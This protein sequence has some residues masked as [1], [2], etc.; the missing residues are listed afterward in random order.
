MSSASGFYPLI[1]KA[2]SS[3]RYY[4]TSSKERSPSKSLSASKKAFEYQES[5]LLRHYSSSY[6]DASAAS[7]ERTIM[8]LNSSSA[9]L[10]S[11]YKSTWLN[12]YC[13]SSLSYS[14][15]STALGAKGSSTGSSGIVVSGV[16]TG[17][18]SE[19]SFW[20]ALSPSSVFSVVAGS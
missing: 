8:D 17:V 3:P 1:S 12:R 13:K 11:L 16:S 4:Q 6:W 18:G 14:T 9:S 5:G 7:C 19:L 2:T 20:G 15:L 10:P